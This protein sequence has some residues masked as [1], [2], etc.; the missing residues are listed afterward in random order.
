MSGR[1]GRVGDLV[2]RLVGIFEVNLAKKGHR[3][4]KIKPENVKIVISECLELKTD[5]KIPLKDTRFSSETFKKAEFQR[6]RR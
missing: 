4:E 5:V 6:M 3:N 2:G 1:S